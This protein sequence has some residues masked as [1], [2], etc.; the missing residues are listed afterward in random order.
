MS[1]SPDSLHIGPVCFRVSGREQIVNSNW[2]YR[3]FWGP[4]SSGYQPTVTLPVRLQ[5]GSVDLPE[6]QP[7]YVAGNHWSFYD[8]M[9]E[10]MLFV[11]RPA[12]VG[13]RTCCQVD[14]DLSACRLHVAGDV[15]DA[16]LRYPLDQILTWGLLGK[17][18]G[19]LLHAAGVAHDGVG[20]VLAG[21]SGAGK[22]TLSGFCHEAGWDILN[23]DRVIV[24]P[25]PVTGQWFL[26]GTPWHGTGKYAK[27]RT[28][29]LGGVYLLQQDQEDVAEEIALQDARY[30]LMDVAG[31]AWFEEVWSQQALDAIAR[32]TEEVPVRRLRFTR[33]ADA[34]GILGDG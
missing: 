9:D 23:D 29:P 30:T 28:V 22:S 6:R 10:G 8:G 32:L 34:V 18:S 16:P 17:C 33:S 24:H 15:S 4:E 26:S 12:S 13:K 1:L 5:S 27:N 14:R 3:D 2:A 19:V 7:D 31:I 25:D 21:R 11:H 20:Y